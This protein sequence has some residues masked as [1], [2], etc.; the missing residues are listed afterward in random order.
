MESNIVADNATIKQQHKEV[1]LDT[2][3][4]YMMELDY[5]AVSV[6]SYILLRKILQSTK[7]IYI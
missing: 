2:K 5:H 7:K 4:Q 1:L 3:G 6:I